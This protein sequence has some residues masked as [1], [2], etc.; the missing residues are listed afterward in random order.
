MVLGIYHSIDLLVTHY[1]EIHAAYQ[2]RTNFKLDF[3]M[4]IYKAVAKIV[5]HLVYI[6]NSHVHVHVVFIQ[7]CI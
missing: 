6:H 2:E 3:C 7:L 5:R 1:L 4:H